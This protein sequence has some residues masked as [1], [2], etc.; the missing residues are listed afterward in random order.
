MGPQ[1]GNTPPFIF[2][3][4]GVIFWP[5]LGSQGSRRHPRGFLDLVGSILAE[6]QPERSHMDLIRTNFHDFVQNLAF[7]NL[8]ICSIETV[9]VLYRDCICAL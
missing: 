8:Y 5:P 6:Y 2:F 1:R 9:Y 3:W 4:G 7:F